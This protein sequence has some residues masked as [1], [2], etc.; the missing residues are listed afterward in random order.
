MLVVKRPEGGLCYDSKCNGIPTAGPRVLCFSLRKPDDY[1]LTVPEGQGDGRLQRQRVG[2]HQGR[3]HPDRK[4][5]AERVAQTPLHTGLNQSCRRR[6]QGQSGNNL[7]LTAR[8]TA[9]EEKTAIC[10]LT[11]VMNHSRYV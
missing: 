4:R 1:V 5:V 11:E 8:V 6:R 3:R 2:E 10:L 7:L 9:S